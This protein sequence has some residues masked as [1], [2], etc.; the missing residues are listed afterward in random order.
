MDNVDLVLTE[1]QEQ[2]II[3]VYKKMYDEA[4]R[5]ENKIIEEKKTGI[6]YGVDEVFDHYHCCNI[7][8]IFSK[9]H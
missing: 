9:N 3:A 6:E 4:S 8:T 7:T 5:I 1:E 2:K